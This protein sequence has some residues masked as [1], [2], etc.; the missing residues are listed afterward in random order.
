M[1]VVKTNVLISCAVTEKLICVF[2]FSYAECWF[3]HDVAHL[4][5]FFFFFFFSQS[6]P[7]YRPI[8]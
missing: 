8:T 1:G 2:V 7:N 6:C 4:C 5:F 3:P